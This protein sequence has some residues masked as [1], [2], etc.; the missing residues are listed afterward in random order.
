M[1]S[2]CGASENLPYSPEDL[3]SKVKD[4][5]DLRRAR[6]DT[7]SSVSPTR[8]SYPDS[9]PRTRCQTSDSMFD[10]VTSSLSHVQLERD[11]VDDGDQK[12]KPDAGMPPTVALINA[13]K[14]ST[15][16]LNS[17]MKVADEFEVSLV[18][19][20]GMVEAKLEE[21]RMS[22]RITGKGSAGSRQSGPERLQIKS[23]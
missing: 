22:K 8:Y 17:K 4:F 23:Q 15:K 20:A 3:G 21:A 5:A 18:S 9:P 2:K 16:T 1:R 6:S 12:A 14:V 11:S 10:K 7:S 13:G 19:L